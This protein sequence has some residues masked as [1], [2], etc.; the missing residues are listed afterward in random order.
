MIMNDDEFEWDDAKD[1]LNQRKHGI[2]FD[3]SRQVFDDFNALD[4]LDDRFSYGEERSNITGIANGR[5]T[6]VTYTMVRSKYRLISARVANRNEQD[7]YY[8]EAFPEE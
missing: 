7:D 3:E 5:L 2:S 8:R 6:T 1:A 4:L